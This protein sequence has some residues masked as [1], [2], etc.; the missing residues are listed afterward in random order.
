MKRN[1]PTK[2]PR[3]G[4]FSVTLMKFHPQSV[5]KNSGF[6]MHIPLSLNQSPTSWWFF[7][8]HEWKICAVVKLFH[9]FPT[10]RAKNRK[11]FEV[12][13]PS[14]K[15]LNHQSVNHQKT[16]KRCITTLRWKMDLI[17]LHH[18]TKPS[19]WAGIKTV[20]SWR[21]K[22]TNRGSNRGNK[23]ALMI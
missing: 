10:N 23:T 21:K 15:M 18:T 12:S 13:P 4:W 16:N 2:P 11:M 6:G 9:H 3:L 7:T 1:S 14:Q 19:T 20:H 17:H 22:S 8:T 5:E